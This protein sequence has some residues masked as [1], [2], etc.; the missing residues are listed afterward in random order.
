MCNVSCLGFVE[1][2]VS[3]SDVR[4]RRVL[5]VGSFDVNGSPRA[6]IEILK[7]S[8]YRGVDIEMGP[9]VDEIC[10][11]EDLVERFG[12]ESFDLLISTEMI[13]HVADWKIVVS[14]F[15]RILK[16]GG[17]I[18]I[19]TRSLG[20]PLHDYPSDHWRFE[21]S[22]MAMIFSDFESIVIESDPTSPGVFIGAVKPRH[23]EQKSLEII[24]LHSMV[25]G[26]RSISSAEVE[27]VMA[28]RALIESLQAD[29]RS[30]LLRIE[31]FNRLKILRY[32]D[33]IRK[34]WVK[35]KH[36]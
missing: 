25:A 20:F 36:R 1:T 29:V 12:P 24:A 6:L 35:A 22:D 30:Q 9:G 7:P 26:Q 21:M 28:Q 27:A 33:R 18:I 11:A 16:P 19:T 5:E 13:E 15:K 32:T 17:K 14:N 8:E 3:E 4:G 10:R 34:V 31:E 23:F 2:Y